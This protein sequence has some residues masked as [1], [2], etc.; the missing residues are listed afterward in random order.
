[1]TLKAGETRDVHVRLD[2]PENEEISIATLDSRTLGTWLESA[3]SIDDRAAI[4]ALTEIAGLQRAV[5]DVQSRVADIDTRT[6]AIAKDQERLRANLAGVPKESDL[7][8]RYVA[9]LNSQE[10]E[11]A[12]LAHK[13]TEAQQDR[14]AAKAKLDSAIAA[15]KF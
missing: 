4:D 12:D 3:G 7:A 5:A 13:R 14:T 1:V 6:A 15:V 2:S 11:L 9:T 8:K 10:T